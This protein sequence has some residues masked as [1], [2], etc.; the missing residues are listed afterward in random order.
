MNTANQK[1]TANETK[2]YNQSLILRLIYEAQE[3]SR[4]DLARVTGLTR[5]T[6]SNVVNELMDIGLVAELG[7]APS[8]GGKPP[9]LLE[10]I[11][12]ARHVI[13]VD[14]GGLVWQGTVYDLRG[15]R[16]Y[17]ATRTIGNQTG[18]QLLTILYDLLDELLQHNTRP[19]LGI[20]IGSPG[21]MDAQEGVI[22][23]AVNL[24]WRNLPL[25]QL[26]N[27]RYQ[28][29]VYLVNDSQAAALAEYTF[30]N[31]GRQSSLVVMLAGRG[32][33][34]GLVI[35][36]QL[37]HGPN[38]SGASEIGHVRVVE[39]GELCR[40]GNFGC[41]ETVASEHTLIR[42]A[43]TAAQNHPQSY[44]A[45][46][47]LDQIDVRS[48]IEARHAGDT[49]IDPLISQAGRYLG[50]AVANLVGILNMRQVVI[51]GSL[52]R[53]GDALLTPM[54]LELKQRTLSALVDKTEV[55]VTMLGDEIVMLGASALLLTNE[56][57]VV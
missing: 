52:A 44:L 6:V 43:R 5:A 9:T 23:Q 17:R 15:Q 14:L 48:L 29:P 16:Q 56:L 54:R 51:A 50:M 25:R 12:S 8:A 31:Q 32:I 13:G 21:L 47:N 39:G 55:K 11:P 4:A 19:L 34:A 40:C 7:Q 38:N 2:Q 37:Y 22:H 24:G 27:E 49:F 10:I 30:A 45:Q 46:L 28:L 20:G 26:L 35:N 33:S 18:E 3:V 36:G 57:G 1:V 42:W 41:L 53:L